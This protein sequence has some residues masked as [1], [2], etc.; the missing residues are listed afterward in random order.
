[1]YTGLWKWYYW[2]PM[3]CLDRINLA[4]YKDHCGRMWR[5]KRKG[6][7]YQRYILSEVWQ[8]SVVSVLTGLWAGQSGARFSAGAWVIFFSTHPDRFCFPPILV[9][10]WYV[11]SSRAVK[12]PGHEVNNSPPSGPAVEICWVWPASLHRLYA[13]MALTDRD[14]A[15]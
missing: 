15:A 10:N 6:G 2:N 14:P 11:I 7:L 13:L 4:V 5:W 9:F 1:M 8:E 12:R 3:W